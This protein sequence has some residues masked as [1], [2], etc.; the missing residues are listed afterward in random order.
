[1]QLYNLKRFF[2]KHGYL[3]ITAAWL[4]TLS[5]II[6]NY[7]SASSSVNSVQK[8]ITSYI[9]RAEK[10]FIKLTSD[11]LTVKKILSGQM[12]ESILKDLKKRD[13][14]LFFYNY[15]PAGESHLMAWNTQQ[16]LPTAGLLFL[17]GKSGFVQLQNGFYVWNSLDLNGGKALALVPVKYNY[18]IT[19]EYL[20]NGF[21]IEGISGNYVITNKGK[22]N[23]LVTSIHG[24]HLFGIERVQGSN[25]AD[26][27]WVATLLSIVAIILVLLFIQLLA[28]F[29][30][31]ENIIRGIVFFVMAVFI[32]RLITYLYPFPINL[33]QFELFDPAIYGSS[34]ILKSLGDLL[35]NS[36]L[37]VWFI[38]FLRSQL[39]GHSLL[40]L[41]RKEY[42]RYVVLGVGSLVLV[43]TTFTGVNIITSLVADSQISFDVLNFFTLNVYSLIG[44]IVLC[45]ISIGY[46]FLAQMV[47]YGIKPYF[48]RR[49]TPILLAITIT[50]LLI[51]TFRV[52]DIRGGLEIYVMLWLIGFTFLLNNTYLNLLASHI[53]SSK[54]V[55]WLFFFSV[56]ISTLIIME[57]N[58]K[59]IINRKHYAQILATKADPGNETLL[60]SMLTD[61]RE[62]FLARNF[63]R[64]ANEASNQGF[65]DSLVGSN[66]SG[67][68]DRYET[69]IYS[70]NAAEQPLYN[71][72]STSY[73]D[74]NTILNT[75]ARPTSIS[76]LYYYDV[77]YDQFSYI[78]KKTITNLADSLLGYVFILAN[79]KQAKS[80]L[81]P[82][83]F[84]RGHANS[85]ESSS[86]YAFAIYNNGKLIS[87][88]NDYPFATSIN[89]TD[90]PLQEFFEINKK[91]H[92]ELWYRAGPERMIVIAK[93][94]S[95]SI[96][97]I[98]L[99]SYL[100][101]A[102]LLLT[103]LFWFI[104]VLLRSRMD[105]TRIRT[106][107]QLNIR[108]QIHGTI[109]FIS[110][111]SFLVIG[112]ATI[113]FFIS[114]YENTNREKLSRTIRIMENE[115]ARSL[116]SGAD[117]LDSSGVRDPQVIEETFNKISDIHG[118][119]VNLYDLEGR[120][121]YSSLPL[122]YTKG[123]VSTIMDPV[124]FY[125][126][127]YK[128]EVQYFQTEKIGSL[129]YVSNYIP[130]IDEAGNKFA[131]L[132]IP[133]FTSQSKLKEEIS[134]FLVTIINLNAF[135][136]L[137]AGIVA[138]FITNRIT[139][140]FS[141]IGDKM[142]KINLGRRNEAITWTRG[143]EIG[144]LV[145]E[146]NKMVAKLDESA[147]ALAKTEREGAWR[148]M[149]K[150]IAHEIKN[151]LTPMKLSMQYLQ[152]AIAQKAPDVKN[153]TESVAKTLVEQIDHLSHIASEFSQFA[154]IENSKMEQVNV[155]EVI[156]NV[157]NLYN[158]NDQVDISSKLVSGETIVVADKSHLTRVF[159]NLLQNAVQAV[160]S[161]APIISV[162]QVKRDGYLLTRVRDNGMGIPEH[163]QPKI[164]TPNF[165]TKSSGTG[166]GLAMCKR[167]VEQAGGEI[168]FET[169]PGEGSAFYVKLPLAD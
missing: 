78:S 114:R 37:F 156:R 140:T 43:V 104:N 98:T 106:Y 6:D 20:K 36:I 162:D 159:T 35:I 152:K 111:I 105:I 24:K 77:S 138:L 96:E 109:I 102:F 113:L 168:W 122:P 69:R 57:N 118:T 32:V 14:F 100:F 19:N 34:F 119:D 80:E 72:D 70:Y 5:V 166:L 55:F 132:N 94:K 97:S 142:K 161:K 12:D 18:I 103:F 13:Y 59:E 31:S 127:N 136:F 160:D 38:L 49:F 11:S 22:Q 117:L 139:N 60:N 148:E 123:I 40:S 86:L 4:L 125:H 33:R 154:N 8:K 46:F 169:V 28:V 157:L 76:G 54:L 68:T 44:F 65:K 1:M 15:D 62:D 163:V 83:L 25:V 16:V 130:V 107:W 79:P 151:P 56:S 48:N 30:A 143:D 53:I 135:I 27:N 17:Q 129:E 137:V 50:S 165:T 89:K 108:N 88:H 81:Y 158:N 126:L 153:L 26:T 67:Y 121:K 47:V 93:E 131:Y 3:L 23:S 133:Y 95:L 75:Q 42:M 66:F 145:M 82:E 110:V 115:I 167:M 120:M 85:I 41:M 99:F 124:A 164:F 21:A 61:F 144:Q 52:G 146:Y 2:S 7:W 73:N 39:R 141:L 90:F 9:Q 147:E 51:L 71:R 64:F 128:R 45:C 101:C 155:N 150:Q 149:A 92:H 63:H 58:R 29:I 134:N 87:S 10:D 116:Q 91:E 84:G 74:L 112:I